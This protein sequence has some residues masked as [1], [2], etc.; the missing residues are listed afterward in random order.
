M[1]NKILGRGRA[2][3]KAL[4]RTT[5][6]YRQL[7]VIRTVSGLEYYLPLS[8]EKPVERQMQIGRVTCLRTIVSQCG[9]GFRRELLGKRNIIS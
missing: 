8:A 4:A 3:Y 1:G 5:R 9:L 2:I 6:I 7:S